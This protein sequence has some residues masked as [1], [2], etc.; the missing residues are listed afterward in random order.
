MNK[1]ILFLVMA[2]HCLFFC[3]QAKSQVSRIE[4]LNVG[5]T[6]PEAIWNTPLKAVGNPGVKKN[7][8]LNDSKGKL[9]ILDFWATWCSSCIINFPKME[10]L[11]K[12]FGDQINIRAVTYESDEKITGFFASKTGKKYHIT[13]VV[14]DS[15]LAKL[16]PH[17]GIPHC[18]WIGSD[19]RVK[20]IT[21]A[22]EVNA[23]NLRKL[24]SG[25]KL[26]VEVKKDQ[27]MNKPLFLSAD[28]PASDS[29]L[30]Y[31]IFS[32]GT[33]S[34][35]TSGNHLR[36][37][38]SIVRGEA[39]TN[40]NL[41]WIYTTAA[42]HLFTELGE[43]YNDKR[44]IIQ[45]KEPAKITPNLSKESD[46]TYNQ[47]NCYNYDLVVPVK[48]ATKLYTYM[49]E[50]LNRYTEYTGKIEKV[51]RPCLVLARIDKTDKIKTKGGKS[52]NTLFYKFPF[53]ITNSPMKNLITQLND[54]DFIKLPVIDETGYKQHIDVQLSNTR[55]LQTLREELKK[56][57]LTLNE[58]ERPLTMFIL[59]DKGT[60]LFNAA[61]LSKIPVN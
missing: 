58:V 37:S 8:K 19:G 13:S 10:A 41:L 60:T 18:V 9:I 28:F 6:V 21:G 52:T 31:S 23:V 50:D 33:Y 46:G 47:S 39:V 16:F 43:S 42:I 12:E 11:A 20:A 59:S 7:I 26:K 2:A 22:S 4:P 34:G 56:Y 61:K 15:L 25:N 53:A 49:L 51:S 57:G 45:V 44:L 38:G 48:E 32:K 55:N 36:K 3:I 40:S 17:R 30:H 54:E 5:D 24:L 29:L 14:N 35:L 1:N 27:A